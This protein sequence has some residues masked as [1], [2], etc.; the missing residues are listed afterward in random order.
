MQQHESF[1]LPNDL[2]EFAKRLAAFEAHSPISNRDQMVF[3]AGQAAARTVLLANVS[4]LERTLHV[5]QSAAVVLFAFSLGLG[6]SLTLRHEQPP[7]IVVAERGPSVIP[8]STERVPETGILAIR[9]SPA[10]QLASITPRTGRE[11]PETPNVH[12][13]AT[14]HPASNELAGLQTRL[15]S[16][17]QMVDGLSNSSLTSVNPERTIEFAFRGDPAPVLSHRTLLHGERSQ[18]LINR[19]IEEPNL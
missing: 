10:Q 12:S 9:E 16:I 1:E 11:E 13:A 17:E 5:W 3:E 2:N 18:V 8:P 15:A 14:A 19:L 6:A 7:Q 4:S